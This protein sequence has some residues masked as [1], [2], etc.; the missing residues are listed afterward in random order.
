[1]AMQMLCQ[2]FVFAQPILPVLQPLMADLNSMKAAQPDDVSLSSLIIALISGQPIPPN[3][4]P[5]LK[6]AC[7]K[8]GAQCRLYHPSS[9]SAGHTQIL[10]PDNLKKIVLT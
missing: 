4:A 7:L 3:V 10:I 2:E 6:H 5:A 9:S 8:E 1:M